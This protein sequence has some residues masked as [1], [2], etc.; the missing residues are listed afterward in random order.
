MYVYITT[1]AH[2]ICAH[3]QHTTRAGNWSPEATG[4]EAAL[5]GGK[6]APRKSDMRASMD[7]TALAQEAVDL[8]VRLMRWRFAPGLDT[9]RLKGL[10]CLLLGAGAWYHGG[11]AQSSETWLDM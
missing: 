10:R 11:T 6:L 8:N 9:Q 7:P 3:Y 2:D 1:C 5:G 4:W